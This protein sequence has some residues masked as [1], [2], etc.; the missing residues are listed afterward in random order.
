[1]NVTRGNGILEGFLARWR[2]SKADGLIPDE[3]RQGRILDIGCGTSPLFLN[4][5]TFSEKHGLDRVL[6]TDTLPS[7]EN[8]IKFKNHDLEKDRTIPYEDCYFNVVSMLAVFE[9]IDPKML[10]DILREIHR[11]LKPDGLLIL[12][13]PAAWTNPLLK[14]LAKCNLVSREEIEEH[15]DAYSHEKVVQLMSSAGFNRCNITYG[16]FE[17]FSNL[18]FKIRK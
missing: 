7:R 13:T 6:N 9:H 17:I 2:A 1:M 10:C 4:S 15:K 11:V 16:Y 18:W 3:A 14:F 12:T 5:I 8:I